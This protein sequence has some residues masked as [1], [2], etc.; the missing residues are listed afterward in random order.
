[1]SIALEG[2]SLPESVRPPNARPLGIEKIRKYS[3]YKL[4]Q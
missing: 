2:E 1:V 3:Q 4:V